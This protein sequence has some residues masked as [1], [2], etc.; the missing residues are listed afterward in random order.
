MFFALWKTKYNA[1]FN[2]QEIVNET[3]AEAEGW[4]TQVVQLPNSLLAPSSNALFFNYTDVCGYSTASET[5]F[6]DEK[7]R[8]LSLEV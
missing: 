4:I 3:I 7:I 6:I 2:G 8:S 5:V 1:Y